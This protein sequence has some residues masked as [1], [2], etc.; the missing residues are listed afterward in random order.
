L[1]RA[2]QYAQR[3]KQPRL[4]SEAALAWYALDPDRGVE[5]TGQIESREIRI[6]TL[7]QMAR[8]SGPLREEESKHLLKRAVQEAILIPGLT[9]RVKALKEIAETG[10]VVDKGQA[11]AV[12]QMTYRMI[13]KA[14]F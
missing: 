14:S 5:M 13:E 7:C 9:E 3:T 10:M 11:K 8:R 2:F 1:E 4:L 6:K 12:Y